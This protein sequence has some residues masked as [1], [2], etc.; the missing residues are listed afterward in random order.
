MGGK[1]D[2]NPGGKTA[3]DGMLVTFALADLHPF[4]KHPYKVRDDEAMRDMVES[5]RQY[6]VL[7]PAIARLCQT[8]ATSLFQVTGAS[9]LA[10]WRGWRRCR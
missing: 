3:A 5:I 9:G 4:S 6:G 1:L 10:S 2:T 7:S 8:V